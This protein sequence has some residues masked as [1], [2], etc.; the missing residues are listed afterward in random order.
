MGDEQHR[1]AK[2]QMMALMQA[3]RPWQEAI[4]IAGVQTSRSTAYRWFQAFST[5]GEATLQ[6]GG[7][8]HRTKVRDPVLQSSG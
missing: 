8:A 2:R 5:R 3:D 4:S 7:H 1:E 6:D